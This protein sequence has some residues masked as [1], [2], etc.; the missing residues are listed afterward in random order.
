MDLNKQWERFNSLDALRDRGKLLRGGIKVWVITTIFSSSQF[1]GSSCGVCLRGKVPLEYV[2]ALALTI[3]L[4]YYQSLPLCL[5]KCKSPKPVMLQIG[6]EMVNQFR[7]KLIHLCTAA[8][9]CMCLC[10]QTQPF[11]SCRAP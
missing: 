4:H 6:K 1:S 9:V 5:P 7:Q 8:F 3:P 2:S 10:H 11:Q